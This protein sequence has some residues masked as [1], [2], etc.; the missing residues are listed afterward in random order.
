MMAAPVSK[1]SFW[2]GEHFFT[3]QMQKIAFRAK[4]S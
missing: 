3:G 4:A 2:A 1:Y